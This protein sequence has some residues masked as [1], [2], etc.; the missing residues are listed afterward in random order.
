MPDKTVSRPLNIRQRYVYIP[1]SL[2][3]TRP[4]SCMVMMKQEAESHRFQ[5]IVICKS[6]M[7]LNS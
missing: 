7:R 1:K 6:A 3:P 5:I 4:C 2:A